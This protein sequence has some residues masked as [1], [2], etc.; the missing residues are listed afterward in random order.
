MEGRVMNDV[1]GHWI[2]P[3]EEDGNGPGAIVPLVVSNVAQRIREFRTRREDE[4]D[5]ISIME[6]RKRLVEA[7]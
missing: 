7:R 6:A 1:S 2:P 4:R 5:E 3:D